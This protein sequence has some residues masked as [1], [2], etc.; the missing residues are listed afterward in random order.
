M[1]TGLWTGFEVCWFI[2]FWGSGR[3]LEGWAPGSRLEISD[4]SFQQKLTSHFLRATSHYKDALKGYN[5]STLLNIRS[6]T[7]TVKA[8][9][10]RSN[11]PSTLKCGRRAYALRKHNS[12]CWVNKPASREIPQQSSG[13]FP[14]K[15]ALCILR[16]KSGAEKESASSDST[17]QDGLEIQKPGE[18]SNCLLFSEIDSTANAR[19]I[20]RNSSHPLRV[21]SKLFWWSIPKGGCD[22]LYFDLKGQRR[23][24]II[25]KLTDTHTDTF[26]HIHSHTSLLISYFLLTLTFT[27]T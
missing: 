8:A 24:N 4:S 10:I 19:M 15:T 22:H 7:W 1:G 9:L 18:D 16:Q 3:H 26:T 12:L 20:R 11:G 27:Y 6:G 2:I 21:H 25:P 13:P 14:N 17:F 23:I 5:S